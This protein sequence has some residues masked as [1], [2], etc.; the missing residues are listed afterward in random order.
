MPEIKHVI[1]QT[2][3]AHPDRGDPGAVEIG[4]YFVSGRDLTLCDE[5][6]KPMARPHRLGPDDEPR[7]IAGRLTRERW[8]KTNGDSDFNRS[9]SYPDIGLA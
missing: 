8:L 1:I 4:H 9:L 3:Q 2:G 5:S 7:A 6:G